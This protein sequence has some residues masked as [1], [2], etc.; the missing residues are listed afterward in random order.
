M[1]T[2]VRHRSSPKGDVVVQQFE[3]FLSLE[4][5]S[6][7][8][9]SFQPM[10]TRLDVFLRGLLCQFY[11]ELWTFCRN[12]LLLFH[13]QATVETGFSVNKKVE[14]DSMLEDS[15]CS[16]GTLSLSVGGSQS[17]SDEEATGCC[18]FSKVS[19]STT[20]GPGKEKGEQCTK[21]KEEMCR[22]PQLK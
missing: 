2:S 16:F 6:E 15:Y 18:S 21:R 22:G 1:W 11:S 10:R 3:N 4:A 8:L 19:A 17:T 13:C 9:S 5:K 20:P 7:S 12:P 14:A